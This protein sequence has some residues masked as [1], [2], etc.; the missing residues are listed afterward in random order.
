MSREMS[1]RRVTAINNGTVIDHIPAGCAITVLK[2]LGVDG[3]RATPVTLAMNVPSAKMGLKDIVKIE[4]REISQSDLDKL[5]LV[6]PE[7]SV[8]IIR[9][10]S[11]AEKLQVNLGEAV[12]NVAACT[13][14]NCASHGPREPLPHRL[15]VHGREPL[16]LRCH[17]CGREQ[18]MDAI[19]DNLL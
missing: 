8:S 12:V 19:V 9:A 4:D 2:M 6:A 5:A 18:D 13:F 11:V 1:M 16:Q 3:G 15:I 10:Y 7:A 14:T 17:Y